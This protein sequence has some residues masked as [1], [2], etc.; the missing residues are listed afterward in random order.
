MPD[1]LPEKALLTCL[2]NNQK[3]IA[4]LVGSPLSMPDNSSNL[5]VPGV[6]GI[7][8]IITNYLK[9]KDLL[10]DFKDSVRIGND[11][12]QYQQAFS[13]VKGWLG[14]DD[15]NDIIRKSVLCSVK[16]E[17]TDT[18]LN[19]LNTNTDAWHF[20]S[21]SKYM[22]KL[23]S[24]NTKFKGPI[25][26][27]NFDPLLSLSVKKS[28]NQCTQTIL[29]SDGD[30]TQNRNI[31]EACNIVHLHGYWLESD[32]LHT[33]EQLKAKRPKLKA[34]LA[35][36]LK[37]KLLLVIGYGGWDD[38]FIQALTE[39][40]S[41]DNA[42]L[43]V[44]WAFF[45]SDKNIIQNK[46]EKL[47]SSVSPAIE[48]GR[49]RMY[50]GIDCHTFIPNL[51]SEFE[52]IQEN[53]KKDTSA[54]SNSIEKESKQHLS[55]IE[56]NNEL[57]SKPARPRWSYK[58]DQAHF[59][60]RETE[61]DQFI[62]LLQRKRYANLV[63]DWGMA[64]LPFLH[65]I[66][67]KESSPFYKQPVYLIDCEGVYSRDALFKVVK[68]QIGIELQQLV[69]E[70]NEV[71][72]ILVF[73]NVDV[74]NDNID[75]TSFFTMIIDICNTIV[76]FSINIKVIVGSR[77]IIFGNEEP[78]LQISELVDYDIKRYIENHSAGGI[79]YCEKSNLDQLI[80]LSAGAPMIL[81]RLLSEL[82][83]IS[84]SE[85]IESDFRT[86]PSNSLSSEP[87]PQTLIKT[88]DRLSNSNEP[89]EEHA[90]EL[91][92]ILSVLSLGDTFKN[93]RKTLPTKPF[94]SSHLELLYTL[95]LL[96]S[97]HLNNSN[98]I[99]ENTNIADELKLLVVPT[100]VREYIYSNLS[101]KKVY[102]IVKKAANNHFGDKWNVGKPK[103]CSTSNQLLKDKNKN[104]GSSEV[105]II[106]LLRAAIEQNDTRAIQQ[107][108]NLVI[109]Y[110]S[111]LTTNSRYRELAM[112]GNEIKAILSDTTV[113][114]E[115]ITLDDYIGRALRMT[116]ANH[117]AIKFT[118]SAISNEDKLSKNIKISMFMNLAYAYDHIGDSLQAI[119]FAEK[120]QKLVNKKDVQFES[121][122][123]IIAINTEKDK[124]KKLLLIE[125]N[126]RN[127]K[128][129]TLADNTALDIAMLETELSKKLL[130][131]E[132][133]IKGAGL[134]YNKYCAVT[135]K[136]HELIK[137]NKFNSV[138]TRDLI[139]L[140]SAYYYS[141]N[142]QSD[143]IFNQ[144]H[145]AL[146]AEAEQ[147]G[148]IISLVQ[149][150]K[151]SS[152]YWRLSGE[153]ADEQHYADKLVIHLTEF[154]PEMRSL[155]ELSYVQLRVRQL[156]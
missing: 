135:E 64:R 35:N 61:Q 105:I 12:D 75:I 151:L 3:D 37:G 28:G 73:D 53:I 55:I 33:T 59:F 30:L 110:C 149:L 76:D 14:Q 131:Y 39:L 143:V 32:T 155:S 66:V 1:F 11:A 152:L 49:F 15:V 84:M 63:V 8:E 97:I 67:L 5:G 78:T 74:Y 117:K 51:Y 138:S 153:S 52:N 98:L 112:F 121:A 72:S 114:I 56:K 132:R 87:I 36:L 120:V 18:P 90:F 50:S 102:E 58:C 79:K 86:D 69:K 137:E 147:R 17:F 68:N 150:F 103:I 124:N 116:G 109:Y 82:K 48:R 20:P 81:D 93:V 29:H 129:Y 141:Y 100:L 22:G 88:I 27:T 25:L 77:K 19:E 133:V 125:R 43:D 145:A 113:Q 108:Y 47:I 107:G 122:K 45:E 156:A 24:L 99:G 13:F 9:D 134:S 128:R 123:Y 41:D 111:L 38:V 118:L 127:K 7:L 26:T 148:D 130:C 119:V 21:A 115:Y 94:H 4:V 46:Y 144:S 57:F 62:A 16:K 85:L 10:D 44:V 140:S 126:A 139:L 136:Y 80:R 89:L 6:S 31:N 91:L 42:P 106:Q 146:W 92:K 2:K 95:D 70:I 40:M 65:S 154:V 71:P 96:S 34:S 23:I 104:V 101:S 142:Q 83:F 60:V 54:I